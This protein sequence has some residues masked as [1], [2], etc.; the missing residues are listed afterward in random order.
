[1]SSFG[2]HCLS[3]GGNWTIYV[4]YLYIVLHMNKGHVAV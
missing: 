1:M 2:G 4:S 3:D